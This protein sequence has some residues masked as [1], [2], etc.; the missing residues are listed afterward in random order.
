MALLERQKTSHPLTPYHLSALQHLKLAPATPQ[1][2]WDTDTATA[3][4]SPTSF[5]GHRARLGRFCW[6]WGLPGPAWV[7]ALTF[8]SPAAS[9]CSHAPAAL[10]S[11]E[12]SKGC[13]STFPHQLCSKPLGKAGD[14]PG[15]P[16]GSL[17]GS[18]GQT[19]GCHAW[20]CS[21]RA[22]GGFIPNAGVRRGT[23][24]EC[25]PS[26]SARPL[27]TTSAQARGSPA[28]TQLCHP[29][30]FPGK[31][32][33]VINRC[34]KRPMHLLSKGKPWGELQPVTRAQPGAGRM[35][36]LFGLGEPS[37]ARLCSSCARQQLTG[38]GC[39][40]EGDEHRAHP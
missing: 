3:A 9:H 2:R 27:G 21:R 8:L 11:A 39:L 22:A 29:V 6:A 10:S 37:P 40:F 16:L 24:G 36:P 23:S 35:R 20:S 30:S 33:S 4:W 1:D 26:H 5:L 28:V 25:S 14:N 31:C 17:P 18:Q 19:Q 7:P 32:H 38:Q 15:V 12:L 34:K 13:S